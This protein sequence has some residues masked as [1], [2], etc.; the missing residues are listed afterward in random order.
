ME[1]D[2]LRCGIHYLFPFLF[3][4]LYKNMPAAEPNAMI[5]NSKSPAFEDAPCT[6]RTALAAPVEPAADVL[7]LALASLLALAV[8]LSL[9]VSVDVD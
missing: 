4:F 5:P 9:M 8:P 6:T 2:L 3:F 1:V 7:A